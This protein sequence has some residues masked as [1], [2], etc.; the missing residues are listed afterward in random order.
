MARPSRASDAVTVGLHYLLPGAPSFVTKRVVC[1]GPL[2]Y[3]RLT[4]WLAEVKLW[5][6]TNALPSPGWLPWFK[7]EDF[8][9]PTCEHL[10]LVT[11]ISGPE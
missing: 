5:E 8:Y 11:L 7:G 6:Q 10:H 3:K 9:I 1:A 4:T 2:E